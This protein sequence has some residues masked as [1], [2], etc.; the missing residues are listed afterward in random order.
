[1]QPRPWSPAHSCPAPPCVT[2]RRVRG[3]GAETA[4][5]PGALGTDS[6]LCPTK[7]REAGSPS[8]PMCL[9]SKKN[10]SLYFTSLPSSLHLSL[11][12]LS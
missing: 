5:A 8:G 6:P 1:M 3:G 7:E 2:P 9:P 11:S 4:S 12:L 10:P